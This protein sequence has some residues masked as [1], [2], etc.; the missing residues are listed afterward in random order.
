MDSFQ[1]PSPI[2]FARTPT[3]TLHGRNVVVNRLSVN[4]NNDLQHID[5]PGDERIMIVDREVTGTIALQM[6]LQSDI[7]WFA[8]A[9]SI[10]TGA[11]KVVHGN[12]G[13]TEATYGAG[14]IVEL[15]APKVQVT[16]PRIGESQ[17]RH[18]VE[19]DL[20]FLP[21]ADAGNDELL[22]VTR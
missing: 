7:D 11:L 21:N 16:N 14:Q 15:S 4:L 6:E 13:A 17:G 18:M 19:M 10:T 1:Q 20:R 9:R 3:C 2:T 22:L 12:D 5:D 8:A